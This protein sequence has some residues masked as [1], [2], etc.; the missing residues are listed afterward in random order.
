ML[1]NYLIS[2]IIEF[3]LFVIVFLIRKF[4]NKEGLKSF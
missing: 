4:I 1:K 2:G 3:I